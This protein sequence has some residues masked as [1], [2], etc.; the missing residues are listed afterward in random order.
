MA[1]TG[2]GSGTYSVGMDYKNFVTRTLNENMLSMI[3]EINNLLNHNKVIFNLDDTNLTQKFNHCTI[4]LYYAGIEL[5]EK[6]TLGY[7]TDCV[8]SST[9]GEY[10]TKYNSQVAN[11]PAVIYSI[12][13]TRE[14]KWKFRNILISKHGKKTWHE[15][16]CPRMLFKLG[17]DTLTI[18]NPKDENP[19]HS[20]NKDDMRQYLHG[21]VNVSGEKFSVGYVFRVVNRCEMYHKSDDKM[22]V[23]NETNDVVDG[24]L[25]FDTASFHKRL[26]SLYV[27]ALL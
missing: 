15:M 9:T 17:A 22:V 7:H 16:D 13:D 5:K 1:A 23:A 12:G 18:I 4:L 27:N 3:D 20:K 6:T 24:I 21:G 2:S 8:Y 26:H 10:D 14:L 11:T 19:K 25:G